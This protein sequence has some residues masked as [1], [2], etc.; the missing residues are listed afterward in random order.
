MAVPAAL[1][2]A[3]QFLS[4]RKGAY[5]RVFN[6]ESRDVETVLTDLAKFCRAHD[7]AWHADPRVHAVMEGRRE[8]WLRIARHLRLDDE[9]LFKLYPPIIER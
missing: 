7:S 6:L 9:T 3:R 4:G 5:C 1:E 8:V 2:R